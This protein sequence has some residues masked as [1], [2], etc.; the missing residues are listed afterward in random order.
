[1]W[2]S[3]CMQRVVAPPLPPRLTGN[4]N[5]TNYG[6]NLD[7]AVPNVLLYIDNS[8]IFESAKKYSGRKKGYRNG[9]P[10]V[11]CR[12]DIGKLIK[13]AVGPR[14]LLFGKLYGSEPPALDT[15]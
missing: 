8:N 9:I 13:K 4:N 1:M 14:K 3:K 15:G 7:A 6:Y 10:D 2:K 11:A 5:P 12:I